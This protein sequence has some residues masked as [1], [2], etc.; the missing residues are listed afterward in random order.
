MGY[1]VVFASAIDHSNDIV[2]TEND[3]ENHA[4]NLEAKLIHKKENSYYSH[5]RVNDVVCVLREC[6]SECFFFWWCGYVG[7]SLIND[8]SIVYI[9]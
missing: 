5:I 3:K 2:T 4:T 1:C 6:V 8:S 9:A 7:M